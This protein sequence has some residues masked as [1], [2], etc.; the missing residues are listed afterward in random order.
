MR[1]LYYLILLILLA[2][3]AAAQQQY[4]NFQG[5]IATGSGPVNSAGAVFEF[6]MPDFPAWTYTVA[7]V[8]VTNGLYSLA[9][10]L[11]QG[12]FDSANYSRQMVVKYNGNRI[13]TVTL[14]A[15]VERD[16]TV[17]RY[18]R[19]SVQWVNVRNKPTVDTSFTNEL[20]VLSKSGDT[21][22]LSNGGGSVL[23]PRV[24]D[25]LRSTTVNG[26][27]TI[28]DTFK[29]VMTTVP[30]TGTIVFGATNQVYWQSFKATANGK[31][32]QLKLTVA[33][34][35]SAS[36]SVT[37]YSGVGNGTSALANK[38]FTISNTVALQT[39]DV[40]SLSGLPYLSVTNGQIY[41]FEIKPSTGNTVSI[42]TDASNPYLPGISSVSNTTDIPFELSIDNSTPSCLT[43]D[44]NC[45]MGVGT[46]APTAQLD[47]K[48]RIK[49]LTGFV[50][51]P[52]SIIAY[53][54]RNV[55]QGW[56]LCDGQVVSRIT[57][58]DLFD[59]IDT[60][61]GSGTSASTFRLPDLRGQFLR[62][63]DTSTVTGSLNSDPDHVSRSAAYLG[64][65][66]G[67]SVGSAQQSQVQAHNHTITSSNIVQ[68]TS[69]TYGWAFTYYGATNYP[70]PGSYL[71][72]GPVNLTV[73]NSGGNE[74]RPRNSYVHYI[75]KY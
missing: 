73:T 13:D 34:S 19:D 36:I 56:L 4:I 27:L 26:T 62:G 28:M 55:P 29:S 39:L 59:A 38:T 12:V 61:W 54:G 18:I 14:Y 63:V 7:N 69:S 11:P 72:I 42:L 47:V 50:A 21:L 37:F 52:G 71:P 3:A 43:F 32:R 48:G 6:T 46:D 40:S 65:N 23:L 8:S 44:A 9:V 33:S 67:N 16:P 1:K 68:L 41:T 30:Q 58:S 53:G 25:T 45:Q 64:G 20:Q 66:S 75:I 70:N 24:S 17:A 35:G 5:K 31:L 57:Y 15:P 60:S 2:D 10:A 49:D 22:K 74:T 51:P